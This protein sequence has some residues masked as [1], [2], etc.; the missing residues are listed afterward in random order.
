MYELISNAIVGNPTLSIAVAGIVTAF[1]TA[2]IAL[3][4]AYQVYLSRKHNRLSV[5][6]YITMVFKGGIV[7]REGY[8]DEYSLT[9]NMKNNGI[10]PGIIQDYFIFFNGEK[11]G[12]NADPEALTEAIIN[13]IEFGPN[14]MRHIG[15]L[16]LNPTTPIPSGEIRVL[17]QIGAVND[18]KVY[19]EFIRKFEIRY[20][21]EDVYG[22]IFRYP[23]YKKWWKW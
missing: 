23:P 20:S 4:A 13:K 5:K 21:Y 12:S 10:G 7:P 1:I 3:I 11:I 8:P 16:S 22:K 9:Y 18:S 6:P 15:S 2:V 14:G 19:W 17:L